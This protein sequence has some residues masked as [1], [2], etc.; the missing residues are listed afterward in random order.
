[1]SK[2]GLVVLAIDVLNHGDSG[3]LNTT[4]FGSPAPTAAYEW[5]RNQAFVN[6]NKTGSVGH[7][8]GA[9]YTFALGLA[10]PEID[11]LGFQAFG[12]EFP[13]FYG[14][15]SVDMWKP[16]N[17][18]IIQ[19]WSTM[20]EYGPEPN[21]TQDDWIEQ[22]LLQIGINAGLPAGTL[23][24]ESRIYGSFESG[25]AQEYVMHLGSHPSQT[26]SEKGTK[27]LA[28]FF[29]QGLTGMD[30]AAADLSVE[31]TTYAWAEIWGF[32]GLI[33]L[34]ISIIP[35]ALLLLKTNFFA[36]LKQ[37]MPAYDDRFVNK[38][39]MWWLY[40]SINTV[41]GGVL[42]MFFTDNKKNILDGDWL[43]LTFPNFFTSGMSN[44]FNMF[45]TMNWIIAL[46]FLIVMWLILGKKKG[47]NFLYD[48][49]LAFT[50]EKSK[51][52]WKRLGKTILLIVAGFLYM[53]AMAIWAK[54]MYSLEFRSAWSFLKTF[55]PER[56]INFW[57]YFPA[58]LAFWFVNGGML[59]FGAF[60]QKEYDSEIK[61]VL[62]WWIKALF[63][64]LLGLA[65]LNLIM[66]LPYVWGWSGLF[67]MNLAYA[68][69][70]TY[71]LWS[72]Y[73]FA[74]LL[75]LFAII[76]YRKTGKIYLGSILSA[77]LST[78]FMVTSQ[79]IT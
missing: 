25:F 68:P 57:K 42:Y 26:H 30:Q 29:L 62:I 11:V 33:S 43:K 35:F 64:M 47:M 41:L 46:T 24:E 36:P 48:Y 23:G 38:K 61:T 7:S 53:Y 15:G 17:Q 8:M 79:I 66:Y 75:I 55:T 19:V 9:Y 40:A 60:R 4:T 74:A 76:L 54:E 3:Y 37:E 70:M 32:I 18:S 65:L 58:V 5:L 21:Q 69:M 13:G 78:W 34:L 22:N 20:E 45:Y 59:L 52:D 27:A 14:F 71:Q 39:G 77:V 50:E 16:T 72:F 12:T 51:Y 56:W 31:E 73:P 28:S 63:A 6:P 1:M 67:M 49:G 10:Y 44:N 2:R